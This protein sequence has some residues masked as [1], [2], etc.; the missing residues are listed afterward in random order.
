MLEIGRNISHSGLLQK[1]CCLSYHCRKQNACLQLYISWQFAIW[2]ITS[3]AC[4]PKEQ[5][6]TSS[7]LDGQIHLVVQDQCSFGFGCVND[8]LCVQDLSQIKVSLLYTF[9]VIYAR[10]V[11]CY[12]ISVTTQ[13]PNPL[14]SCAQVDILNSSC[15]AWVDARQYI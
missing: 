9:R 10:I 13:Q 2:Q 7:T 11:H 4:V 3:F 6:S 5:G 14:V 12:S 15:F 8:E 1:D